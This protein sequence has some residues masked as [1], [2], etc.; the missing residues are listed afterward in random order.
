MGPI[1]AKLERDHGM[2]PTS[3]AEAFYGGDLWFRAERGQISYEEY[4][5][6][7]TERL[8][9]LCAEPSQAE[10]AWAAWYSAFYQPAFMP[11][12]ISLVES[13]QGKVK[14]AMLSNASPGMEGRLKDLLGIAHLFDPLL[15]SAS[16]GC[17]KPDEQIYR[18]ALERIGEP[19]EACFFVDDLPQ[20]I[21]A[22]R[23]LGIRGH[24]FVDAPSVMSAMAA[25]GIDL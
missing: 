10:V 5:A 11:G 1:L 13:L 4:S 3:L 6:G 18:L 7:C 21:A 14:V 9:G 24:V 19:A 15:S 23:S 16:L 2:P 22:A 20:N 25:E 8:R 12:M 17:A